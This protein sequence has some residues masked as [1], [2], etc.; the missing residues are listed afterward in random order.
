M[1]DHIVSLVLC[2]F[3]MSP[4]FLHCT[5]LMRSKSDLRVFCVPFKDDPNMFG[6]SDFD[7]SN[8]FVKHECFT[9]KP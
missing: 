7:E 2:L 1:S 8:V 9:S 5:S 4:E 6:A 3:Q